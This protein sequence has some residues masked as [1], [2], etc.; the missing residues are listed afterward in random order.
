MIWRTAAAIV[1]I[2]LMHTAIVFEIGALRVASLAILVTLIHSTLPRRPITGVSWLLSL[3]LLTLLATFGQE[4]W[5]AFAT[6]VLVHLAMFSAFAVTLRA[7]ETPLITRIAA[8][9][10]GALPEDVVDY[11]RKLTIAW[12]AL[13]GALT[14]LSIALPLMDDLVLWSYATNFGNYAAIAVLFAAEY[15]YRRRRF[16]QQAHLPFSDHLKR[17]MDI[18]PQV[19]RRS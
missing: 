14:V 8:S 18:Y 15:G 17:V 12:A 5:L 4:M 11:C 9:M 2:G 10:R 1:Y 16:P 6:P 13:L 7:N 3:G 19:S